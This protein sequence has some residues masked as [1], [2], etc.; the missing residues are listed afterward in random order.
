MGVSVFG[1]REENCE[2]WKWNMKNPKW[3]K[4]KSKLIIIHE[5]FQYKFIKLNC[6]WKLMNTFEVFY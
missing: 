6:E 2:Q 5:V 1:K 4:K 3:M